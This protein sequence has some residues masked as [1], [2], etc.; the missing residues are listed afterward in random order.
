MLGRWLGTIALVVT[1]GGRGRGGERGHAAG[2][3][4]VL[5]KDG[6]KAQD[7]AD[8]VVWVEG[9]TARLPR[10]RAPP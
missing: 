6:R 9:P 5:E 3:V 7:T 10:R 4:E 8:A 2:H 1:L